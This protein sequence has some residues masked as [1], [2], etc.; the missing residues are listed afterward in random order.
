MGKPIRQAIAEIEK[1]A[2]VCDYYF[3]NSEKFLR[4]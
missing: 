2:L 1:C 4:G 3:K